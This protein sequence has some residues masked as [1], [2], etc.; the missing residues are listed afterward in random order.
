MNEAIKQELKWWLDRVQPK[1]LADLGSYNV[2]GNVKDLREDVIGFDMIAGPDVDF[3]L[4][5][6]NQAH[7]YLFHMVISTSVLQFAPKPQEWLNTLY[8]LVA[9]DG[10]VLMSICTPFCP[11]N[12]TTPFHRDCNRFTDQLLEEFMGEQ[13]HKVALYHTGGLHDNVIYVGMPRLM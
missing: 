3:V 4:P 6:N 13:F 9:H 11:L 8:E 7:R 12:H 10:V 2:N 1:R 5:V